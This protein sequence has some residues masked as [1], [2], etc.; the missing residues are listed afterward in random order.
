MPK[1]KIKKRKIK[2]KT[3][4]KRASKNA[5]DRLIERRSRKSKMQAITGKRKT[6]LV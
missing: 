6:R 5:G 3:K 1:T 4:K 2:A